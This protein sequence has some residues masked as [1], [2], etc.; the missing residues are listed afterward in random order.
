M[1]YASFFIEVSHPL[2]ESTILSNLVLS[3]LSCPLG[4]KVSTFDIP[5]LLTTG[6]EGGVGGLV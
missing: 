3:L 6:V 4:L 5:S 1:V 2:S